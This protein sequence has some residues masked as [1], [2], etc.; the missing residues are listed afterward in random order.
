MNIQWIL[1]DLLDS[2]PDD[3]PPIEQTNHLVPLDRPAGFSYYWE[4][5]E[6]FTMTST[7]DQPLLRANRSRLRDWLAINIDVQW[8]KH[9]TRIEETD[10]GV[11]VFFSDGTSATGDVLVGADG[12]HSPSKK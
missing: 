6:K 1:Q 8:D 2:V 4:D 12:V 11:T 9:M 7:P 10:T 5:G 3:L